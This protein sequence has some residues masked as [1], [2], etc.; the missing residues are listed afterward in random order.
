MTPQDITIQT[1][2]DN[3][4]LYKEKTP[5]VVSGEFVAWIDAFIHLLPQNGNVFELGS[6]EGRDARYLRDRGFSVFCTD[7]IPRALESLVADGFTTSMY[8]LRAEPQQEWINSYDGVFAKAVY[9]HIPQDIFE[10]SLDQMSDVLK[11]GGIF[12]CTFK[13]G[14]GEEMETGKLGGERYFKY[15]TELELENIFKKHQQYE[16][17]ETAVTNDEKWIQFLLRKIN[18]K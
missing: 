12:C 2:K 3:F 15:Y 17:I 5:N 6:A 16:V 4:D 8:D 18:S 7:V 9:L 1:Y 10:K 13:L 14:V 11:S